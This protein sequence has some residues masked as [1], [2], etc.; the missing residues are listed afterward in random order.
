MPMSR[1]DR[2]RTAQDSPDSGF[3]EALEEIRSG[4]KRGHWI[5]Y[6]FPQLSGLGLSRISQAFAIEGEEEAAE[7]LRDPVLGPRLLAITTEVADQLRA[8]TP[9]SLHTLMGSDTDARKVVSSLTLFG[10]VARKVH[11]AEGLALGGA[12]AVAAD[13]VLEAAESQGYPPCAYTR[14]RLQ[15]LL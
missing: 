13:D 10:A 15:L 12:L 9:P 11:A 14:A 6:V 1:L 4:G 8:R 2:F 3:D 5:W 7:F